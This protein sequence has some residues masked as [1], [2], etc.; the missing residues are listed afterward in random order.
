MKRFIL[1]VCALVLIVTI[2]GCP[3]VDIELEVNNLTPNLAV[4][5]AVVKEVKDAGDLFILTVKQTDN[6]TPSALVVIS[7][8]PLKPVDEV[9]LEKYGYT[10]KY[11]HGEMY[12]AKKK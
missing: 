12:I 3:V 9:S 1:L 7:K 5:T 2:C 6:K 4:K 8:D 11:H 10:N